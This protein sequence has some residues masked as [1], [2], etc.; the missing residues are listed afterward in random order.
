[1]NHHASHG[2]L[3]ILQRTHQASLWTFYK[4][5]N[6]PIRIVIGPYTFCDMP[7]RRGIGPLYNLVRYPTGYDQQSQDL[8]IF[9]NVTHQASPQDLTYFFKVPIRSV[10]VPY[11]L[12]NVPTRLS[13]NL[14]S[15]CGGC[16]SGCH[17][18]YINNNIGNIQ[19]DI[20]LASYQI[21][22]MLQYSV[23][24]EC[25]YTTENFLIRVLLLPNMFSVVLLSNKSTFGH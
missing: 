4:I 24:R 25:P 8:S 16:L 1:M 11:R 10:I 12:S 6:V 7:P 21:A 3:Q 5:C 15:F 18:K 23:F 19:D 13:P 14:S 20:L 17:R 22:P 2:T 9:C